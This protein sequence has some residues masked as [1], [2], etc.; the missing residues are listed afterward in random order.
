[1]CEVAAGNGCSFS[2]MFLFLT[3]T[4]KWPYSVLVS[5]V[6]MF[7]ASCIPPVPKALWPFGRRTPTWAVC[8]RE[9]RLATSVRSCTP[10][11]RALALMCV[12][13]SF[14]ERTPGI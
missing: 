14:G 13:A 11:V 6:R 3:L 8:H 4:C 2:G 1:M 5:S 9:E 7:S 10:T 12:T